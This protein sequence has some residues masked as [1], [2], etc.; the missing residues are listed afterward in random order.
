M[1]QQT[2][3]PPKPVN[4]TPVVSTSAVN[5]TSAANT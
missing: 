1:K 4:S 3:K 2:K 5:T